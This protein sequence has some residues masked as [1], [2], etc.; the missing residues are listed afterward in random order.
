MI[1]GRTTRGLPCIVEGILLLDALHQIDRRPDVVVFVE[2]EGHEDSYTL[3]PIIQKYLQRTRARQNAQLDVTWSR[4]AYEEQVN[5]TTRSLCR[6]APGA[7]SFARSTLIETDR[8]PGSSK[9]AWTFC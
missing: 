4:A 5:P 7:P 3:G 8:P 1:D 2:L 6:L 9:R